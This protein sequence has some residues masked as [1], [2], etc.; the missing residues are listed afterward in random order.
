MGVPVLYTE[1]WRDGVV[2]YP[3]SRSVYVADPDGNEI[4][5]TSAFGGGLS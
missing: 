2:E 5:L 1:R 4:E 3:Q